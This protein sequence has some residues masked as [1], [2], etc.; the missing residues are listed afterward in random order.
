MYYQQEIPNCYY[1]CYRIPI[2]TA[3]RQITRINNQYYCYQRSTDVGINKKI[4]TSA[5]SWLRIFLAVCLILSGMLKII[6]ILCFKPF[7]I[8]TIIILLMETNISSKEIPVWVLSLIFACLGLF[9]N[10]IIHTLTLFDI[11]NT[12]LGKRIRIRV[13]VSMKYQ[14]LI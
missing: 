6:L 3:N 13:L 1:N 14:I 12:L 7:L 2:Q 10:S 4:T 5:Y 9:F 8:A 11:Q